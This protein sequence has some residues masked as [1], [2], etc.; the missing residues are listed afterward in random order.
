MTSHPTGVWT[1]SQAVQNDTQVKLLR[2]MKKTW[3]RYFQLSW[4]ALSDW[5]KNWC[6]DDETSFPVSSRSLVP[7]G[8]Q[9]LSLNKTLIVLH[10][11]DTC[12]KDHSVIKKKPVSC[13]LHSHFQSRKGHPEFKI[14]VSC[15][16]RQELLVLSVLNHLR[17]W[18]H[19]NCKQ[20]ETLSRTRLQICWDDF[21]LFLCAAS[22][23]KWLIR[24]K[25]REVGNS[26]WRLNL[27]VL[28]SRRTTNLLQ[29]CASSLTFSTKL[30]HTVT[31]F[32]VFKCN[33]STNKINLNYRISCDRDIRRDSCE[34]KAEVRQTGQ[35]L[36]WHWCF[37][38]T[39]LWRFYW[40]VLW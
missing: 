3:V 19:S 5:S 28:P 23:I 37:C 32:S 26:N 36:P 22:L 7:F 16:V 18:P 40:G 12:A 31:I 1:R 33:Q 39:A 34:M 21:V 9:A 35:L 27:K 30:S 10:F 14:E 20:E 38:V 17:F 6:R 4:F 25:K 15:C 8:R 11:L 29:Q 24:K 13:R 2:T